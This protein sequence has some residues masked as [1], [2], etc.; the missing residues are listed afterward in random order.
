MSEHY[1]TN[2]PTS[3]SNPG[4]TAVRALGMELNFATD[5]GVFAR[6]GFD[7]GSK[8]LVE[9]LPELH[10]RILDLGCGWGP[11]GVLLALKYPETTVVMSDVNERALA[12]T[13]K[14]IKRH[15]LQNAEAALS[16]EFQNIAGMF[17]F[18]ITNPPIRAGKSVI[19]ALFDAARDRL[20]P[21][22]ALYI[23]IRKQHGAPS[24]LKHLEE[25]YGHAEVIARDKGFWII[26]AYL[27]SSS[28][29]PTHVRSAN[30]PRYGKA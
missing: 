16:D 17:D 14:N 8:L 5:A 27:P 4:E 21:D 22:G 30:H 29:R 11:I 6:G 9:S 12:L 23:V 20:N 2:Q 26:K 15:R 19:Y 18:I 28:F 10:G 24:A 3:S 1:Y 13:K 25:V 7:Y